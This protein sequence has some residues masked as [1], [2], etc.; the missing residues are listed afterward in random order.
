[1]PTEIGCWHAFSFSERREWLDEVRIRNCNSSCVKDDDIN[2]S[3]E[4]DG[5]FIRDYP[6]FFLAIGEAINGP[7]GYFGGSLDALDDC[8][9]GGF[10]AVTPFTLLWKN[11][12]SSRDALT[13]EAWRQE[14]NA[15]GSEYSDRFPLS[16][17]F[18]AIVELLEEHRVNLIFK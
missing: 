4:I 2:G 12:Q 15:R 13:K 6:S 1:M 16:I 14:F 3:Y 7:G 5:S 17:F 10:G 9:L 11:H 8:C 18:E